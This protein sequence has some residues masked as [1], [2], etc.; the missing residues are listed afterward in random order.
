MSNW[1]EEEREEALKRRLQG[2]AVMDAAAAAALG[3]G[4]S[5]VSKGQTAP[6]GEIKDNFTKADQYD[7]F[8]D[9]YV[10]RMGSKGLGYYKDTGPMGPFDPFDVNTGVAVRDREYDMDK[11][12][13]GERQEMEEDD[14]REKQPGEGR[15]GALG[16]LLAEN[17]NAKQEAIDQK[18]HDN[19]FCPPKALDEDEFDFLAQKAAERKAAE[20]LQKQQDRDASIEF[21]VAQASQGTEIEKPADI[22]KLLGMNKTKKPTEN[23]QTSIISRMMKRK[24]ASADDTGT[25]RENQGE[26]SAGWCLL[27]PHTSASFC[28]SSEGSTPSGEAHR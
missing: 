18:I 26:K 28:V 16:D 3:G 14:G 21:K 13:R 8:K 23:K 4:L 25:V 9:G 12:L 1:T 5:F 22:T 7:G 17:K 11:H 27:G 15:V 2:A 10:Y 24:D 6:D 20:E 19:R